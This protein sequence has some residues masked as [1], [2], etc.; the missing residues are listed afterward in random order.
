MTGLRDAGIR[1]VF[2][3]GFFESS[4]MAPPHFVDHPARLKDF[5][6]IADTYFPSDPSLSR[7]AWP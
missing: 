5:A 1:A 7:W 6:R 3:Y 4:P 2:G